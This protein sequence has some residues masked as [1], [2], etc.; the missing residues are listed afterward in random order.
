MLDCARSAVASVTNER[1]GLSLRFRAEVVERILEHA[2]DAVVVL[3][4]H[5]QIAVE[6]GHL[7]RPTLR[8]WVCGGREQRRDLLVE[9][10]QRVLAQ[11]DHL[12]RGV[13]ALGRELRGPS[14][15]SFAEPAWASRADDDSQFELRSHGHSRVSDECDYRSRGTRRKTAPFQQLLT[16]W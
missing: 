13:G 15:D 4:G 3:R 2:A 14:A 9:E 11:I 5:E 12:E 7:R 16:I 10:R 6:L 8:H 1:R